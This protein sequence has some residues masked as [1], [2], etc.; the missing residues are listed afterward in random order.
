MFEKNFF[1]KSRI[2]ALCTKFFLILEQFYG[3]K[4][5]IDDEIRYIIKIQGKL[6]HFWARWRGNKKVLI[7]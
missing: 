1:K 6:L 5:H 7:D 4:N 2:F 3:K